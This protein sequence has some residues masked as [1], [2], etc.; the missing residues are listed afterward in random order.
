MLLSFYRNEITSLISTER[1]IIK[2]IVHIYRK[3]EVLE[4]KCDKRYD[5]RIDIMKNWCVKKVSLMLQ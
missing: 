3:R 2:K 4:K 5:E 1:I